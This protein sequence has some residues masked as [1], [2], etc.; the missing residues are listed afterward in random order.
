MVCA[1]DGLAI[2]YPGAAI[3]ASKEA[4]MG[5]GVSKDGD[6]KVGLTD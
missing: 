1:P 6:F 5:G 2:C 3:V 4:I